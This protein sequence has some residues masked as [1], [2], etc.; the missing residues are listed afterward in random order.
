MVAIGRWY[1]HHSRTKWCRA[2]EAQPL[3]KPRCAQPL[4]A[5]AVVA[6]EPAVATITT[7]AASWWCRACG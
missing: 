5:T 6:A 4:D 3:G 2:V 1:S 7:T